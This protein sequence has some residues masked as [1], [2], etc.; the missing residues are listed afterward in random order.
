MTY[1]SSISW[2][3]LFDVSRSKVN[4]IQNDQSVINRTKLLIL[5]SPKEMYNELNFG[6]GIKNYLFH[7]NNKS[8]R[9]LVESK[10]REQL[11]IHE[12]SVDSEKT[13]FNDGLLSEDTSEQDYNKL[14]MT[15]SLYTIYGDQV[16]VNLND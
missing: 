12:P 5:S 16:Q 11:D 15:V 7:Y 1:T 3:N 2:P 10:I 13:I 4:V 14:K 8:T 6:V 9:T